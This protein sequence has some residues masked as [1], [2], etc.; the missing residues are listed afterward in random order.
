[1][2]ELS[3][4]ILNYRL[5]EK[6]ESHPAHPSHALA[7]EAEVAIQVEAPHLVVARG[8]EADQEADRGAENDHGR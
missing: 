4:K 1:M 7:Q 6:E 5:F 2:R 8:Q 3:P